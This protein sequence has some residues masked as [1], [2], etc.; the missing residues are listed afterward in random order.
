MA[1]LIEEVCFTIIVIC[2]TVLIFKD[3]NGTLKLNDFET[4]SKT[5]AYT[6]VVAVLVEISSMIFGAISSLV[7]WIKNKK[8]VKSK[9]N[10]VGMQSLEE[11]KL[12]RAHENEI[13]DLP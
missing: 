7:Q 5:I 12:V 9:K 3:N 10:E 11:Q 1:H 6:V 13:V 2:A 8:R 4:Y